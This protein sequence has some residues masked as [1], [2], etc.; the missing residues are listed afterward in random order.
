MSIVLNQ[1]DFVAS[2]LVKYRLE[3]LP[4]GE[5]WEDAHYPT[6]KCLK[7]TE[8]VPLWSR[9]HSAQGLLQSE[10][11]DHPCIHTFSLEKDRQNLGKY[12][13]EYLP[14]LEK[15]VSEKGRRVPKEAV[16]RGAEATKKKLDKD[17]E[18]KGEFRRKFLDCC[19]KGTEA[20]L[21]KREEDEEFR[22]KSDEH[23]R[24]ISSDGGRARAEAQRKT[25]KLKKKEE[26][27]WQEFP[28]LAAAAA[29]LGLQRNKIRL[30]ANGE[31]SHTKGYLAEW[32][33]G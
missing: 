25:V 23:L 26:E 1:H 15:W 13:P 18:M 2:C 33:M 22:E 6:P 7:G 4:P 20:Y 31:R 9:D 5:C 27:G 12:Y 11:F 14:L 32:V 16:L 17:P 8:T 21:R 24:K 29:A 19:S 3:P 30:V 10:E 28:S